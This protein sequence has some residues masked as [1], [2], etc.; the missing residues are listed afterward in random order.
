MKV[1]GVF[2]CLFL[3]IC[4]VQAKEVREVS[5][6]ALLAT[7]TRY[8]GHNVVVTGYLCRADTKQLG[9]FLTRADCEEANFANAIGVT[10]PKKRLPNLPSLLSVEGRFEDRTDRVFVDEVYIWGVIHATNVSGRSLP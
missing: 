1:S 5:L 6:V 4:S 9:L 2:V 7:P 10:E 8:N 3:A